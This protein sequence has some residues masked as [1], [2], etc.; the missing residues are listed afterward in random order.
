MAVFEDSFVFFRGILTLFFPLKT[1]NSLSNTE[2]SFKL[3]HA[4]ALLGQEDNKLEISRDFGYNSQMKKLFLAV[5]LLL[6][7][8]TTFAF[9]L[10]GII[11]DKLD[12]TGLESVQ[13]TLDGKKKRASDDKGV[14]TIPNIDITAGNPAKIVF[15]KDAYLDLSA[16]IERKQGA[17]LLD[18]VRFGS[19]KYKIPEGG[20]VAIPDPDATYNVG[21]ILLLP[22]PFPIIRGKITAKRDGDTQ[23]LL[24]DKIEITAS[25]NGETLKVNWRN[26]PGEYTVLGY[27]GTAESPRYLTVEFKYSG[28]K[29]KSE[30]FT[31]K[32]ELL[33]KNIE[34]T[35]QNLARK[36]EAM[37][38]GITGFKCN[39]TMPRYLIGANCEDNKTLEGDATDLAM[40]MQKFGGKITGMI[41]MIAVLFI[42]WNS[43]KIVTA[44]GDETKISEA[45]QAYIYNT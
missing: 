44:A 1:P 21:K 22:Q 26:T 19:I 17:L 41:G 12:Q 13:I 16:T 24:W 32:T 15:S 42:I 14:F 28:Y 23:D 5:A 2:N 4:S 35:E 18:G 6:F 9:T 39:E 25:E 33:E 10:K 27:F 36:Q 40:L 45:K 34:F 37:M 38:E 7:T 8:S 20:G 31:V 29:D 30:P 3:L 11:A 43:F